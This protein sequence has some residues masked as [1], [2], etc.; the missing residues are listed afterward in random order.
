[1]DISES[2]NACRKWWQGYTLWEDEKCESDEIF[3]DQ[4]QM[5]AYVDTPNPDYH[6]WK[7][8]IKIPV[9]AEID[10]ATYY[11]KTTSFGGIS[12][13]YQISISVNS[14]CDQLEFRKI[15]D[16]L[17]VSRSFIIGSEALEIDL[18][19]FELLGLKTNCT[20]ENVELR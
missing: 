9:E 15:N 18:S 11:M 1:M 13:C 6:D 7:H 17:T 10:R 8:Y 4:E 2:A 5:I 16:S 14:I 20:I 3:D 19:E 12:F